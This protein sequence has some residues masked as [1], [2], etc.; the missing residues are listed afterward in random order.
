MVLPPAIAIL[1]PTG[2][3][4]SA[5]AM[6]I[7][8]ALPVEIISVDSAQVYRGMDI[9]TA[10]PTAAE[11]SFV[12]HHLIDI[13]E[14][15]QVYSAG[16]FRG[17]CLNLLQEITARGRVPLLVGGTMLYFRALFQGIAPLPTANLQL[18]A[19]IDARARIAG[20]PALHAELAARD[21]QSAARI[22]ANDAQRI[23]R[24][25]EVLELSGRTLSDHWR[26]SSP[27]SSFCDWKICVLQPTQRNLLH[28]ALAARLDAMIAAGFP[29]EVS[30]LLARETLSE[31][32][33]AMRLVGYRQLIAFCR[34]EETLAVAAERAVYATRQL[35]KRQLTWLR[36]DTLLPDESY[37]LR[38][39]P[40]DLPTM[41]QMLRAL[42]E[43]MQPA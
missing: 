3:G 36:S 2:C 27:P 15:E 14:P 5:L 41:E 43:A 31:K 10:K 16:E 12:P 29:A 33:A 19:L 39:D 13:R 37:K 11:R 9:G 23:Q 17:D 7:A 24:A 18:R 42:I 30:K 4:K 38:G 32:S 21:P 25:L 20:W 26:S 28:A 1:G 8:A 34:G 35:A 40:F 22:H 6:R